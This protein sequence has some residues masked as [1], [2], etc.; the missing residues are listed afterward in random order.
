MKKNVKKIEV[1][2]IVYKSNNISL[3]RINNAVHLFGDQDFSLNDIFE[4]II[5]GIKNRNDDEEFWNIKL[6][7][8]DKQNS[9]PINIIYW[10]TGGDKIWKSNNYIWKNDWIELATTFSEHFEDKINKLVKSA[11]TFGDLKNKIS[12]KITI[13]DFY[14]LGI[15]LDLINKDDT[16]L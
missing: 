12:T 2:N 14:E 1:D 7:T 15:M 9:K 4:I 16:L 10:L 3:Y 8:T 13:E 6:T 5:W 11:K